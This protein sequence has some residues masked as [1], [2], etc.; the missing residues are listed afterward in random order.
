MYGVCG[1]C[2]APS[3]FKNLFKKEEEVV[4]PS[5]VVREAEALT[6]TRPEKRNDTPAPGVTCLSGFAVRVS[7]CD[8]FADELAGQSLTLPYTGGNEC[9]VA[10]EGTHEGATASG[11]DVG[12]AIRAYAALCASSGDDP[13]ISEVVDNTHT[14][15]DIY[16]GKLCN[17]FGFGTADCTTC[18]GC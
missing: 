8:E 4:K 15:Y 18:N 1:V 17:Q 3:R 7:D 9:S 5:K 13:V 6:P 11:D 14:E 10:V 16:F 2:D 12:Q